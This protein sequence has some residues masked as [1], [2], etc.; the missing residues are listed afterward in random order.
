MSMTETY[1][2]EVKDVQEVLKAV[3]LPVYM[4]HSISGLY[5]SSFFSPPDLGELHCKGFKI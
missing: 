1:Y 3:H 4:V 2:S 5:F